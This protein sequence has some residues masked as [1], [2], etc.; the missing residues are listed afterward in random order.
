[1][2]RHARRYHRINAAS[3]C[4]WPL[5]MAAL[6]VA[7]SLAA[8]EAQW[9]DLTGRIVLADPAPPRPSPIRIVKDVQVCGDIPNEN[10]LIDPDTRGIADVIVRLRANKDTAPQ[11]H[12]SYHN[13]SRDVTLAYVGCRLHPRITLL[14][15]SQNLVIHNRD[16]VGHCALIQTIVNPGYNSII[17]SLES[18]T[19]R[20]AKAEHHPIQV[21]CSVHPWCTATLV[22]QEH[23]YMAVTNS[24]GKFTIQNLPVGKHTFQFQHPRAGYLTSAYLDH[25]PNQND[26]AAWPKGRKTLRI[27]SGTNDL[28]DIYVPVAQFHESLAIQEP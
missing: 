3:R 26:R 27:Q 24:T 17:H 4:R 25:E 13:A 16:P 5:W 9:G 28:G 8:D 12:P 18:R 2:I 23:P 1:M 15:T 22:I 7:P 19:L 10:L 11:V 21:G 6:C 14:R 20:F